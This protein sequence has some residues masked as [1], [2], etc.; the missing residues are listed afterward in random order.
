MLLLGDFLD[1]FLFYLLLREH[2][3]SIVAIGPIVVSLAD[4][5][6]PLPLI[7]GAL[8]GGSMLGDNL[9]MISDTTIAAT[10]SLGCD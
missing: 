2:Q 9:S 6:E 7:S 10:Q 3:L 8:L 4:K 5:A 1:R